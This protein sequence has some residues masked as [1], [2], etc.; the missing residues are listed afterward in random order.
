ML[1]HTHATEEIEA[2]WQQIHTR[3]PELPRPW[4]VD[5][6]TTIGAHLGPA[7]VGFTCVSKGDIGV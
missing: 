5:V 1:V 6:T 7:G 2:L 4:F 3:F